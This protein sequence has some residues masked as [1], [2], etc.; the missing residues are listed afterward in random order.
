MSDQTPRVP[1]L[2]WSPT[3]GLLKQREDGLWW[4]VTGGWESLRHYFRTGPDSNPQ[5][6]ADAVKLGDVEALKTKILAALDDELP[7]HT[8]DRIRA[9]VEGET[10]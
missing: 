2:W 10:R 9:I 1:E 5:P 8:T 3:L 4:V 7:S 6:P